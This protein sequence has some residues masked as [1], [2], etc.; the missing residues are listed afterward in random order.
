MNLRK[1][2]N[3]AFTKLFIKTEKSDNPPLF[4]ARFKLNIDQPSMSSNK[5]IC[6]ACEE[7]YKDPPDEDWTQYLTCEEWWHEA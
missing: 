1:R 5:I 6:P 7:E 4:A 3:K 2:K